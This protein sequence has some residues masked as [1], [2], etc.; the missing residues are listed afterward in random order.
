[1][2]P[3]AG[4]QHYEM[5]E[6]F[7]AGREALERRRTSLPHL[8]VVGS[9]LVFICF[10]LSF[11][12]AGRDLETLS[13]AVTSKPGGVG[14]CAYSSHHRSWYGK[15]E[16]DANC[17]LG[18]SWHAS[19]RSTTIA[20]LDNNIPCGLGSPCPH[21]QKCVFTRHVNSTADVV[22]TSSVLG[23]RDLGKAKRVL[24]WTEK[25]DV[26]V[27]GE[28]DWIMGPRL[29]FDFLVPNY[30]RRPHALAS[31]PLS[32]PLP[33][34]K[35]LLAAVSCDLHS[36]ESRYVAVLQ[37]ALGR[38]RVHLFGGQCANT[39]HFPRLHEYKFYLSFGSLEGLF[40]ALE[41][42]T[43]PVYLREDTDELHLTP[44]RSHINVLDFA[45]P[46]ALGKYLLWLDQEPLE[47]A[48][49]HEWRLAKE[50]F[51]KRYLSLVASLLPGLAEQHALNPAQAVCCRLCDSTRR[52]RPRSSS[53]QRRQT[54][55]HRAWNESRLLG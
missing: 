27:G 13:T 51:T 2:W 47:Y 25:E 39:T 32:P 33:A 42:H 11:K 26:G 20:M 24:Y 14:G 46:Q 22:I 15:L 16:R 37:Q 1:M 23:K 40:H 12:L 7:A 18:Y 52:L 4:S 50:P 53:R 29:Q 49:Y 36:F 28:F 55:F 54:L 17:G 41:S 6:D 30:L 38:D 19:N 10:K 5:N 44:T 31:L 21:H 45:S 48:K 8:V 43:V 9:I 35:L 34:N 3:H